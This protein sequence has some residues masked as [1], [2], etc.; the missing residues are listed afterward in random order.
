MEINWGIVAVVGILALVLIVYLIRQNQ[1]D[2]K[3]TT[4][5]FNALDR[6]NDDDSELND[7][8]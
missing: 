7:E 3:E 2:E 5:H 8:K 4:E 1:K 6:K